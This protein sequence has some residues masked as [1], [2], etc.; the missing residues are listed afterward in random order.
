MWGPFS[1]SSA[2]CS[3]TEILLRSFAIAGDFAYLAYYFNVAEKPLWDAI[4]WNIPNILIN[5]AMIFVILRENSIRSLG[6][7]ELRLYGKLPGM[8]PADFRRLVSLGAWQTAAG[9]TV[10]AREGEA[11]D[12]IYYVMDGAPLVE[13]SGRMFPL[14]EGVFIGEIAF[15]KR[16]PATATVTVQQGA[17]YMAWK[18]ADLERAQAKNDSFRQSL[19]AILNTDL[20]GKLARA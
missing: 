1:I 2:S 19:A 14:N 9:D 3:E 16:C 4:F 7:D 18:H 15:L 11:L 5:V 17:R 13:K 20:A 6:D 12:R 8:A 10:L